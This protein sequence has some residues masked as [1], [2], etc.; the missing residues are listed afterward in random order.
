[1]LQSLVF[2]ITVRV[3]TH[4]CFASKPFG[5]VTVLENRVVVTGAPVVNL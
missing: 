5:T 3:S 2:G 4:L 1:M